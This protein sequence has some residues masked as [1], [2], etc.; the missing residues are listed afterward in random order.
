MEQSA[1]KLFSFRDV[2][3]FIIGNSR[4]REP[5]REAYQ[6]VALHFESS[7]EPALVQIPV[8]GGKTGLIS[9]L[10]FAIAHQ[11]ALIVAPNVTIRDALFRAVDSGG[12]NCFWRASRVCSPSPLG[13]F[14]ACLDGPTASL[15][16]CVG[17][18][19]VVT[20][21]QQIGQAENRWLAKMPRDFFD[22]ILLDE[23]H[24]NAAISWQR[25]ME[26]FP[27]A[28]IV[29]LTATPFRS[30]GQEVVG[31]P[32]YRYSFIRAMSQGYI[33]TLR[34]EQV[35][36][37]EVSFT[38]GDSSEQATLNDILK[39]R[40]EGWFSRGVA[41]ADECNRHI[42]RNSIAACER[43]R[44]DGSKSHQII[45]AACSVEH[46]QRITTLFRECGY[47][48]AEI[49]SKQSKVTQQ[50]VLSSLR[51]GTL[52][53]IVQ[54]QMLGEG[55]DHPP[56][57]VA[58]IFRPFRSLSPY[59]Q[60][61]GR[62]MRV[63]VQASPG[64][65]DNRGIVVS[66][67]GL[68][69]DRH[70]EEFR[71]LDNEDQ[72]LWTGIITGGKPKDTTP[73]Q[74]SLNLDDAPHNADEK[75]SLIFQPQMLVEWERVGGIQLSTY[76]DTGV[77]DLPSSSLH[78]GNADASV[79]LGPQERRRRAKS[80]FKNEVE[81]SVH[82]VLKTL[83]IHPVGT[84]VARIHP[85]LRGQKNWSASRYWLYYSLNR[86]LGRKSKS[87]EEWSLEE[88]ERA[89]D[90]LPQ[91]INELCDIVEERRMRR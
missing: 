38:F 14:A 71:E 42:V 24:H 6:A 64:H 69:T 30:D 72:A 2:E 25:L 90:L 76:G 53:V 17:S 13:P 12:R 5:Q 79:V 23:G 29:S 68:N 52:D 54:V 83:K 46:A 70:W 16:D 27:R 77:V 35:A 57:S 50:Y 47:R 89:I 39:L 56:L 58:A 49:H 21:V 73:T 43:L 62:I 22:L 9:I 7:C 82:L 37:C 85:M 33:K 75:D 59:V 26:Y 3:P 78:A 51:N 31:K 41:L 8:G 55:F 28:K 1:L 61:V 36:P 10:P 60:F 32:I 74:L 18:H 15:A 4:L 87:G 45:A 63:L 20:N 44:A 19:F 91:L 84:H 67:V 66:H 65:P 86:R 81:R 80:R 11:R 48:A 88:I 34:S 40:E